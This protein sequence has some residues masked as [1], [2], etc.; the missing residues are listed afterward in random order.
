MEEKKEKIK[1]ICELANKLTQRE[2]E[3]LKREIDR[4]IARKQMKELVNISPDKIYEAN[5]FDLVNYE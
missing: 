2:W 3:I 5:K 4:Q 1:Q